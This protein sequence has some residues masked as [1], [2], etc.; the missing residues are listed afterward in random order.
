M[1][2]SNAKKPKVF[3]QIISF[4]L[5]FIGVADII[6]KKASG[7][8]KGAIY[9]QEGMA[10]IMIGGLFILVA[11]LILG[12][13]IQ[14]YYRYCHANRNSGLFLKLCI[15]W[16]LQY[17]SITLMVYLF[18]VRATWLALLMFFFLLAGIVASRSLVKKSI[19]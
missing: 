1:S 9:S 19:N 15:T 12:G 4:S 16:I 5:Y 18:S 17:I 3:Y 2:V 10:A 13:Y 6:S 11:I 7:N 14:D 8:Y